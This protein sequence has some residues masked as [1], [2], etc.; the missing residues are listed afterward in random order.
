MLLFVL[1]MI[2]A[3]LAIW[4]IEYRRFAPMIARLQ[5]EIAEKEAMLAS[6][7]EAEDA[8]GRA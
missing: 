8:A 6:L 3:A 4:Y 1:I 7:R 2:P 5:A